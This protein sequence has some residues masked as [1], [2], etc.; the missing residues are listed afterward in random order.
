MRTP[1]VS[2]QRARLLSTAGAWFHD[3][4][5]IDSFWKRIVKRKGKDDDEVIPVESFP[6][7]LIGR[8]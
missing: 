4:V 7:L 3:G 8:I 1:A 2:Q 5:V 6:Q